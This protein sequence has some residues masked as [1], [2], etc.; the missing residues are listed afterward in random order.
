MATVGAYVRHL[1]AKK[2]QAQKAPPLLDGTWQAPSTN[3]VHKWLGGRGIQPGVDK[4]GLGTDEADNP[5]RS[6]NMRARTDVAA[7]E[8]MAAELTK[9]GKTLP[10]LDAALRTMW[11]DVWHAEVSD[12]SGINPWWGEVHFGLDHNAKVLADAATWRAKVVP[13]FGKS[14]VNV[15]LATGTVTPMDGL[16]SIPALPEVAA[17]FDVTVTVATGRSLSQ[18]WQSLDANAYW[19]TIDVGASTCGEDCFANELSVAFPRFED[20]VSYCPGLIEDEVRSYPLSAFTFL[21]KEAWLPLA[22]GLIGLGK[23]TWVIKATRVVHVAARISPVDAT[24]TFDDETL[25][26]TDTATWQFLVYKGD[27]AGA[28]Q[29]ADRL[30][31]HPTVSY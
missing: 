16:P 27:A 9:K 5:V 20:I 13:L 10:G 29:A 12:C 19:L 30:N 11:E 17:P 18:K 21:Q 7:L 14:H 26:D 1:H 2:I 8:A 4:V 15:D 24:I 6:G 3:S 22:N 31:L 28:L 23:N 25:R